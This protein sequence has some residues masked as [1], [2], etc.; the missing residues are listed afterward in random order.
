MGNLIQDI[1]GNV[2]TRIMFIIYMSIILISGF[3]IIY[4]YFSQVRLYEKSELNRLKGIVSS[5]AIQLDGDK[6]K[7]LLEN[8][9]WMDD[10]K[11]LNDDSLYLDIH[12]P[13]AEAQQINELSSAMY[14]MYYDD[15]ER[16]FLYAVRSDDYIDFRS[17]YEMYPDILL[18]KMNEGGV[19]ER[20]ETE[21]GEWLSAF[22]PILDSNGEITGVLQADIEFHMFRDLAFQRYQTQGL[23]SLAVILLLAIV[24]IPYVRNVLKEDEAVKIEILNQKNLIEAKNRDLN[25]SVNYASKIQEAMLPEK[26]ILTD[27]LPNSFVFYKPRD[28]VSGDFYWFKE[29]SESVIYIATA[30]CTGHGIPGALMSMIGHS[31]LNAIVS[32]KTELL[33]GKILEKLDKAVTDSL[34]NK[35]Y[36][37]QSKDGMDVGLIKLDLNANKIHYAG[38][39]LN[40]VRINGDEITEYKSNRFPIGGGES[41]QK[42]EFTTIEID[43]QKGDQFYMYSDG[44]PD[45]FG[46]AKEKKYLNKNFKKLLTTLSTKSTD[47]KLEVLGTELLKWQGEIE[48]ID[49][50]LVVGISF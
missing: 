48:Q 31:K 41:Y 46:G 37:T 7:M 39:L 34:T 28:V 22:H 6:H 40:L 47:E 43:I 23:I 17:K 20:Y 16:I 5:L 21:N 8:N 26:E 1:L 50:V 42:S 27:M 18:E 12:K 10:I 25:D 19:I 49:D 3:F 45:Q 30:D 11:D 44:F 2:K 14:T 9:I 13:L 29:T 15:E 24:L 36:K 35:K 32:P 33:P 4:G 38:A